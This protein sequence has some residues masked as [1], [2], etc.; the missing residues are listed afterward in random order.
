M[1]CRWARPDRAVMDSRPIST[2]QALPALPRR[3]GAVLVA[4]A[5]AQL[6]DLA[7]FLPAVG[8]MGIGAESNP[9]ARALYL[10]I[11]PLGPA[12]LKAGAIAI[13]LIAMLRVARRFPAYAVP[14]AALA[15]GTGVVGASS[16]IL[17]GL[18]R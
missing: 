14:A 1:D 2:T 12:A 4:V 10:S 17:F 16:N 11:G 9:L 3:F 6:M 5:V 7:T 8:R 15:V 13:I 18:L